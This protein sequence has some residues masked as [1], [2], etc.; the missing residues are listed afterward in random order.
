MDPLLII[1]VIF[2]YGALVKFISIKLKIL[3]VVGYLLLG[4]II[5]PQGLNIVPRDFIE[6][7]SVIIDLSLAIISVL[8]GANLHYKILK[9]HI[10]LIVFIS[11]FESFFAFLLISCAFYFLFDYLEFNFNKEYRFIIAIL[12][13]ALSSATAPATI[14]AIMHELK[15]KNSFSSFLLGTVAMD[16]ALALIFFSFVVMILKVTL[17]SSSFEI[18][19]FFVIFPKL[20]YSLLL[21]IVGGIF[22][23]LIDKIFQNYR[24]IKTTSTLGVVF[25]VFSLSKIFNLEPLLSA[26]IMGVVMANLSKEF[27]LVRKEFD[28]H[29]K[30]II[31]VL[32]FTV[33]AMHLNLGLLTLMPFVVITY[34]VFRVI[35]K[36]VGA[37]VGGKLTK[38]SSF[39]Q[40]YLGIALFP[41]AGIAI[42]LAFSLK[43]EP[44]LSAFAP[45]VINV[46]IATTIIHEVIGPFLTRYVL[47]KQQN[48]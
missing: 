40:K 8:V 6:E 35:G 11:F 38:S 22:S 36:V 45:I 46:I 28:H 37:F 17:A 31:F 7:N 14:L 25:I 21:G 29:L 48:L 13:G 3:Y 18:S 41:Q 9:N 26:L 2:L 10:K 12:F 16:N 4:I 19:N 5:G 20:F 44:S 23:I 1:G 15:I 42:G 27:Y 33:S 34:V 43:D 30:D 32:F 24:T 47:K 39:I